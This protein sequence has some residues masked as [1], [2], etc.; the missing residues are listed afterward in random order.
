MSCES[1]GNDL[2]SALRNLSLVRKFAD[3]GEEDYSRL[4]GVGFASLATLSLG[5]LH[6][7]PASS[8]K[9][10]ETEGTRCSTKLPE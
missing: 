4:L 2:R 8:E 3:H 9:F 1:S 6:Q 5:Q 7:T 10:V